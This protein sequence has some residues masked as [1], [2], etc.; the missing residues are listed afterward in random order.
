MNVYQGG[1]VDWKRSKD[2]H[3]GQVRACIAAKS[4]KAAHTAVV[5]L[6]PNMSLY[7]M[8]GYWSITGNQKQIKAALSEPGTLFMSSSLSSDDYEAAR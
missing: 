1:L 2:A 8:R 4:W 7:Y 3:H 5:K 6:H